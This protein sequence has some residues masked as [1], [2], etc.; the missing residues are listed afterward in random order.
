MTERRREV[1]LR[2]VVEVRGHHHQVADRVEADL[3]RGRSAQTLLGPHL[4]VPRAELPRARI[5]VLALIQNEFQYDQYGRLCDGESDRRLG[6]DAVT[7]P[8]VAVAAGERDTEH[9]LEVL[10]HVACRDR[11]VLDRD[12]PGGQ[13]A[14]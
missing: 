1:D 8:V 13:G 11:V 12:V 2:R 3:L 9:G 10:E 5:E 4:D 14:V 7:D 6:I